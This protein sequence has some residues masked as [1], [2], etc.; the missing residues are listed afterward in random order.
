MKNSFRILLIA[1][2]CVAYANL[3]RADKVHY[4]A[5][6]S[7]TAIKSTAAGCLPGASFK[8]LEINNVRT[9]INTGGDMWWDFEVAQYEIPKGSKKMS[10][11]SASLWIGGIDVNDQLKLAA[12]RYRQGPNGSVGSANDY[13]PGPLT[14]DGTAAI[15]EQT[16]AEYDKLFPVTR[17]EVDE[18]LTHCDTSGAFVAA[19]GYVIPDN[20]MKWPAHGDETKGQ[21][22]YLA[23]FYDS[24]DNGDYEPELGDY[25][26]YDVSNSL[27]HTNSPTAEGNG[28]LV[29]QVIKGDATLWWVFNDKGNIHT[30]T[31]GSPIGLEIRGQAFGFSTNDEVNNMTFYSYEIINRSTFRLR[32]T[33][34]SQWVDT[35]LGFADDDY[36]GCDVKR[37]LG[38]CYNGTQKDGNGQSWAY[39]E[40]P[41]AVGVDF[42]QGPYMD[43]DGLDNPKYDPRTGAN[44]DVSINGVNFE[45]GIKDDER[46]GMRRF[47]YHNNSNSGVPAYMTD[48]SYAPEYYNFLR[49]IWKDGTKMEYGGNAHRSSGAYGPA[50][51]FMF[52]DESDPCN[53]GTGGLPPNGTVKWT[54]QTAGNK[55]QDRRFMQSAGPFTLE[56]GAVNYITVG[57]PWAKAASGGPF[58]SVQLLQV[59][60]DK[61][62]DL[63]D[64]CFK[65]I[66]GPR[67]P[68]LTVKE[69]DRELIVFISNRKWPDAGNN[70]NES[71]KEI[72]PSIKSPDSL[73]SD[74]RF[75]STYRFEGY[76]VYQ[77]LNSQVSISDVHDDQLARPVFQCDIKNNVTQLV[78][79]YFDQ[80]LGSSVPVEEVNGKNTGITHS[81]KLQNDA[82]TEER[83]I[84]HKQYYF[85]AISYGYN[86]FMKYS[87]DPGSQSPPIIGL[88]GQKKPFLA[89]R[90]GI[91]VVTGIPHIPVGT[92]SATSEYG[93]GPI[94]TRIQG[95]GN[96]GRLIDLSDESIAEILSKQPVD[97]LNVLG[98]PNYP[99]SYHPT[100]QKGR[101]PID[102][103]VIDP[104]NVKDASYTL[105][106]DSLYYVKLH[107]SNGTGNADTASLQTAKW[108]LIDN[109]TG[110]AYR[111][112]TTITINNEQLFPELGISVSIK[113]IYNPGPYKVGL[114]A[115]ATPSPIYRPLL[116]NNGFI[117]STIEYADSSKQWYSGVPD[118]DG[119]GVFDWIR[120]G[121]LNDAANTANNDWDVTSG[122]P[123][124]PDG[125]Y[126][127][128][129]FGTVAPYIMSAFITENPAGPAFYDIK[130]P[131]ASSINSKKKNRMQDLAS[132]DIVF[133]PDKTKWTR[134]PVIEMCPDTLLAEGHVPQFSARAGKSVNVNGETDVVSS[135]PTLNSSYIN[136]TGMGWFPGY[137]INIE[138]GERLNMMFGED[139]WL[140][141]DNGR[142]MKFNPTSNYGNGSIVFGGKHYF[143][144]MAH[145]VARNII[146]DLTFDCPAYDAGRN[147]RSG[148]SDLKTRW[149][150]DLQYSNA[151]YVGIPMANPS[152]PFLSTEM[153]MRIRVQKPFHRNYS[154]SLDSL[155]RLQDVENRNFPM[156]SFD[157]KG[158]ATVTNNVE[159]AKSDLDLINVV[160]NPYYAYSPY[161]VNQLDNR[162]KIT[163]LP[164][165]CTVTIYSANGTIIRQYNKDE[166][167]TTIDWDLKNYAGIS[168]AGGIYLIHIKSEGI[169]ERVIK[170][171][172][173]LRPIDL[174]S[175]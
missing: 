4:P 83:F 20:I 139:S 21:S 88:A 97:S 60:D 6:K 118:I 171:F 106:F 34:F 81:F 162:V 166:S 92:T 41:P 159:K 125:N 57:I 87:A 133:T 138:T 116:D 134:C 151:M 148:I 71:Y 89:G 47:V 108:S 75:D 14:T 39:G 172:G 90:K 18:Y 105:R 64:N 43:P 173:A 55:P 48:P 35:D 85:L 163:N 102:I 78:N 32:D 19:P 49:G 84:N 143:Y 152:V 111:S 82:F 53:W 59:V 17:A 46:F 8:Y 127:K 25:P 5:T 175:F 169:G 65:V 144:V 174:N 33:Y 168:I 130:S 160:P 15:S 107:V 66:E 157:T 54:E 155:Y 37:G 100:Y 10:M 51:D 74:E 44:C 29:D 73:G 12:I 101:G 3:T 121:Q 103:K 135:D 26:Y 76:I 165:K 140:V 167:K 123:F 104:L 27:C 132:V 36:V 142:D 136:S 31:T 145:T 38:Y 79:H 117:E 158:I 62:Q 63:F 96:G 22:Y 109:S 52:P 149:R 68:D 42:F 80:A 126:E 150:K 99:I 131:T 56:P 40:Q 146:P 120:S 91:K 16:C 30:E 7:T 2:L 72:D 9:R 128:V 69:L 11:F 112:D 23:P 141:G 113:Q 98:S 70:F 124:D 77:L 161:E 45:N 50:C 24:N 58:A 115:E 164:Q 129:I 114:T 154:T 137:A 13:W 86:E 147:L 67:A 94:I 153:K 122:K 170:F 1:L 156:Y 28:I 119:G 110:I 95:Q 93:D 61:C